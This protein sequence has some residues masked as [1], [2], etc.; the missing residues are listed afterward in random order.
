MKPVRILPP[1]ITSLPRKH[2][3]DCQPAPAAES[4]PLPAPGVRP[5]PAAPAS[6]TSRRFANSLF[7][8]SAPAV[9]GRQARPI[10]AR[11]PAG[12]WQDP[13]ATRHLRVTAAS[14][15]AR[16]VRMPDLSP[17]AP[18]SPPTALLAAI[19]ARIIP[20]GGDGEVKPSHIDEMVNAP[21]FAAA[22]PPGSTLRSRLLDLI[23]NDDL[24][25]TINSI[26]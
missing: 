14:D 6:P 18:A 19:A 8:R 3:A 5:A 17:A 23:R 26:R 20:G 24:R 1:G 22:L 2:G 15:G 9:P 25:N 13:R 11:D 7:S 12:D 16:Y 4:A 10:A 21:E